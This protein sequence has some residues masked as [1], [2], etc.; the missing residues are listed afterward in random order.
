MLRRSRKKAFSQVIFENL[1]IL[2][3]WEVPRPKEPCQEA[4]VYV[5]PPFSQRSRKQLCGT[6]AAAGAVSS[7]PTGHAR[8]GYLPLKVWITDFSDNALDRYHCYRDSLPIT[9]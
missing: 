3:V 9:Y 5:E 1:Q 6:A 8:S 7:G 4:S 2:P